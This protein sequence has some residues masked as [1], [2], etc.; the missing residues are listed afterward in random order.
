M[1]DDGGAENAALAVGVDLHESGCRAIHDGAIE[2][3]EV[4]A[5]RVG[6]TCPCL[7]F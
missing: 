5:V 2:I 1:G 3:G 6:S 4:V 7:Q